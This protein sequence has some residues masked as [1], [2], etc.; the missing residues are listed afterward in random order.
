VERD[1]AD[2]DVTNIGECCPKEARKEVR[3]WSR[4]VA[5]ERGWCSFVG[6]GGFWTL[7]EDQARRIGPLGYYDGYVGS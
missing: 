6:I 3:K 4:R 1:G 5:S 7:A 2:F